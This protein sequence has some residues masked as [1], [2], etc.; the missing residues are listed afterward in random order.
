MIPVALGDFEEGDDVV[1]ATKAWNG[2]L[3]TLVL[4]P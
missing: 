3:P 1:F 4:G 2:E